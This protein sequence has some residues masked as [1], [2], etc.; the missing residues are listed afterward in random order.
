MIRA[1]R[2]VENLILSKGVGW[3]MI[4][5]KMLDSTVLVEFPRELGLRVL[6]LESLQYREFP[7]L[8]FPLFP[9]C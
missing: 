4:G 3:C 5:L 9:H 2:V 8:T 7:E 6:I 1:I